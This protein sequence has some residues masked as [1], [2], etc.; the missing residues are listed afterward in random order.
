[1][2]STLQQLRQ[3]VDGIV[4]RPAEATR[5]LPFGLD[6][7]DARL[8]DGGLRV[9]AL[10]EA[11]GSD[12]GWGDDAA[13]S[14]FLAG[15]AARN[16][17]HV[18]WVVR[19]RDLFA[20]GLHQAG[21]PPERLIQAEARDDN[22]LLAVME[23]ALRYG[24]LAAVVGEVKRAGLTAT[25]RLQLAAEGGTALALL[26][27]R[28]AR[29]GEDPLAQPSAAATRWRIG[30][31]PSAPIAVEGVGRARWQVELVRQRGGDPFAI[32]LEACD[33]TG[34]CALAAELVDRPD[35]ARRADARA[36]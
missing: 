20:P 36:A 17:G 13:A 21:L 14:L 28:H 6:A 12:A 27:R 19:R 22:E 8:A 11:T 31:A 32:T 9:D 29:L 30:S 10:H 33:E 3:V 25:R 23:D 4:S 2:S 15:V 35:L 18:L 1:V 16:P 7:L 26:M 5:A 24:G 34:R